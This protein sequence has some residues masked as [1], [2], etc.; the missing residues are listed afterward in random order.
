MAHI[1]NTSDKNTCLAE[2]H[3]YGSWLSQHSNNDK[4]IELHAAPH[5]NRRIVF[6]KTKKQPFGENLCMALADANNWNTTTPV[7][8]HKHI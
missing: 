1:T 2:R 7:D 3:G 5:G 4:N 8:R 6:D